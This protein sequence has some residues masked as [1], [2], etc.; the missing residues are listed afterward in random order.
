METIG[1]ITAVEGRVTGI[2]ADGAVR[3][4]RAGDPV[5]ATRR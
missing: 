3:V 1:S 4:L 5:H 2:D